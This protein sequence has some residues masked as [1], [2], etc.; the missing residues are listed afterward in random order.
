MSNKVNQ[1]VERNFKTLSRDRALLCI[2]SSAASLN[3]KTVVADCCRL[4]VDEEYE[5][6]Y[7]YE[8]LL[9]TYLFA[10]FPAALESLTTFSSVLEELGIEYSPPVVE[11]YHA[12]K[13]MRRGVSTCKNIYTSV[14]QSMRERLSRVSPHLDEWM[15]IEG[16]GKTL[17]RP[18]LG[19]VSR[20]L[21]N[22]S[23]LAVCGWERQLYS[24][25]RGAINVGATE[26]ECI[27][28]LK[29]TLLLRDEGVFLKALSVLDKVRN[30]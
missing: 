29:C 24:H 4:I 5:I 7:L 30:K 19:I 11:E 10:G 9:Q 18:Q 21:V 2:A 15:I 28:A 25:L 22:V 3:R 27:D 14:Y 6:N 26:E 12:D 17:S 16:Y 20:E 13:F 8:A 23:I 1:F